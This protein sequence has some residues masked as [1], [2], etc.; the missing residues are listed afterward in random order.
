MCFIT[1]VI[2]YVH[3]TED[4]KGTNHTYV[5]LVFI[6]QDI[7][8]APKV[9][10]RILWDYTYNKYPWASLLPGCYTTESKGQFHTTYYWFYIMDWAFG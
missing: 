5:D 3:V 7:P 8:D 1:E 6:S 10:C 2:S 9:T 4:A